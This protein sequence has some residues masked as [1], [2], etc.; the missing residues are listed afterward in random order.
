MVEIIAV[1]VMFHGEKWLIS[2]VYKQPK[3]QDED[4]TGKLKS[5]LNTCMR[6]CRNLVLMGDL[7]INVNKQN[8]TLVD[9]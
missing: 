1:E 3:V 5:L 2:S 6:D 8:H 7:N 4:F 9:V